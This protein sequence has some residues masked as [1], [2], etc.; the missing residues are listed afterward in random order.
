MPKGI[1]DEY[2]NYSAETKYSYS[3]KGIYKNNEQILIIS[4]LKNSI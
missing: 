3:T 1:S 4:S 2:I